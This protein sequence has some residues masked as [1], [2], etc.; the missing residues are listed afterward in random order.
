[1]T[2]ELCILAGSSPQSLLVSLYLPARRRRRA[3]TRKPPVYSLE[4]LGS[5]RKEEKHTYAKLLPLAAVSY[6]SNHLAMYVQAL[7]AK[8]RASQATNRLML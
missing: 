7:A 1:M 2:A 8:R 4:P 6:T 5:G 3:C